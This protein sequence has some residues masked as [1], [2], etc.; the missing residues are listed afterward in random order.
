MR[1]STANNHFRNFRAVAHSWNSVT[2]IIVFFYII[3]HK[4]TKAMRDSTASNNFRTFRAVAHS[5]NSVSLLIVLKRCATAR[6][7]I[8]L[9]VSVLSR[10][11][12]I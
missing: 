4:F 12:G 10:I 6:Q 9:Q 11:L 5:W 1:D 8:I 2:I 7:A 3:Q